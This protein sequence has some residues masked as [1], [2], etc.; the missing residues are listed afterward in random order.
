MRFL[1]FS[2]PQKGRENK[3]CF[4]FLFTLVPSYNITK[5]DI[6]CCLLI[7]LFSTG[8]QEC[9]SLDLSKLVRVF[10]S[11]NAA[12][13]S[14]FF[15]VNSTYRVQQVAGSKSIRISNIRKNPFFEID[16]SEGASVL[17]PFYNRTSLKNDRSLLARLLRNATHWSVVINGQIDPCPGKTF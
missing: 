5:N 9:A 17:A 6:F 12:T 10:S 8:S 13:R 4:L 7:R 16:I 14:Q 2:L 15:K 1:L 3:R 11:A